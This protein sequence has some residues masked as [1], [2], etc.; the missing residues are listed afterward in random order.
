M[1]VWLLLTGERKARTR[2]NQVLTSVEQACRTVASFGI[3]DNAMAQTFLCSDDGA[4]EPPPPAELL[5]DEPADSPIWRHKRC[6][7][8]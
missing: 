6:R 2:P 8:G 5:A 1:A 3:S 4:E 7:S